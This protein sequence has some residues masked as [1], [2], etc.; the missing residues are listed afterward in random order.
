MSHVVQIR[1]Q[2]KDPVAIRAGCDRLKLAEP[3]YGKTKLFSSTLTGWA[4]TL[5]EWRYPVVCDVDSGELAFDNYEGRWG[6]RNRLDEFL[7]AYAVE[8]AKLEARK[9]G[10]SASEQTLADGSIKVSISVGGAA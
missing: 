6:E 4:V 10:Y 1:T 2:V 9:K 3:V 5:P 8:K 7:Q